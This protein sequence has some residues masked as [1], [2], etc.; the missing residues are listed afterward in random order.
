VTPLAF[1]VSPAVATGGAYS[2]AVADDR[3]AFLAGQLAV[4][5]PGGLPG[6]IR[7]ETRTAMELLGQV[8]G[9]LRL[10]FGDVLRVNVYMTD[11]AEFEAM[12]EV[13]ASFFAGA[14]LPARTCVGVAALLSGCRIEI[15]CVARLRT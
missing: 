13:Y 6:D 15:D 9:E 10:G 14:S 4:D 11:L 5:A 3:Y 1:H 12:D 8:L 2:H 7:E